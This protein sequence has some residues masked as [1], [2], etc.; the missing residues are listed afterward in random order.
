M[1]A[2]TR[3]AFRSL[4]DD[5]ELRAQLHSVNAPRDAR[6]QRKI[7]RNTEKVD[8]FSFEITGLMTCFWK[9]S[10]NQRRRNSF[11]VLLCAIHA[12]R[13]Q[14]EVPPGF[15]LRHSLSAPLIRLSNSKYATP[16]KAAMNTYRTTAIVV[17][18]LYI[19]GFV[20]GIAGSVLSAPGQ[21]DS[22]SAK[23]GIIAVGAFLWVTAAVGDAAHGVLMFPI[24]KLRVSY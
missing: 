1:D 2:K 9:E 15:T 12:V 5:I 24:L 4:A 14:A 23:S 11:R 3:S 8:T 17:G 21:L 22:V 13:K 19:L 20:V 18:V 10:L 16:R 7:R 6:H